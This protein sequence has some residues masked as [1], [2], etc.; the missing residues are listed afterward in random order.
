[1]STPQF[2][3]FSLTRNAYAAFDATTLK[4]LIIDRLNENEIFRDQ[5]YEG[6]N[7]NAFIDIVAYM[8]HVLLFYLNT[9]SAESTFTTAQ[10]YENMNKLVS[11]IGY[12]PTGKQTSIVSVSLQGAGNLPIGAYTLPRFSS[13]I[14]NGVSFVTLQEINFEKTTTENEDLSIDNNILHQGVVVEYPLYTG[15]D[16]NFQVIRIVDTSTIDTQ[17]ITFI[18]DNTFSVFVKDVDTNRW[19]EWKEVS[20]LYLEGGT[21]YVYEKRL[22][23]NGNFEFK[24]GNNISGKKLNNGDL[25]QIYY[26]RS[27]GSRGEVSS[28]TLNNSRFVLYNNNVFREISAQIFAETTLIQPSQLSLIT[29]AN[30]FDSTPVTPAETVESIRQNAPKIFATQN[31]LVTEEDYE[32]YIRKN[33]NNI[34]KSVKVL[35]NNAYTSQYLQYF[36]K[37]GLGRPN[38]DI[39]VLFNQV[40][41]SNSTQFN[42]VYVFSVPTNSTIL[43]DTIPNFTNLA[44]KQLIINACGN[45]KDITH[46]IVCADP[47]Y[48]AVAFGAQLVDECNCVEIREDTRLVVKRDRNSNTSSTSLKSTISTIFR[49]F[50]ASL[51]LGGIINLSELSNKILNIDGV[52]SIS[53]RRV[54]GNVEI[55]RISLV[56]W[57]PAYPQ[58]DVLVTSQNYLLANYEYAY[59]YDISNISKYIVIENE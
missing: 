44:Q 52:K 6:S 31:R 45:K 18:S 30:Q 14:S 29:P 36:Y 43:N 42:N 2:T 37:I 53:T 46:H 55:P 4:Q 23:E 56:L 25:V 47:I 12:K 7:L 17:D 49:D 58:D 34:I 26:V 8:Y 22:N 21:S 13:L 3:E 10:L 19:N 1:M 28:G 59:F 48:K 35:D 24:F 38:D 20:S 32:F 41:F 5:V 27:D 57:N 15:T 16:E 39:R 11:N 9:T 54:E 50:F 33:F 40:A 51:S